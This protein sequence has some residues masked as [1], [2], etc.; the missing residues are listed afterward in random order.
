MK[1]IEIYNDADF[2]YHTVTFGAGCTFSDL[3]PVLEENDM[4]IENMPS[5]PHL[6]VVGAVM[7]GT[8]GSGIIYNAFST[9]INAI[10]V[11]K[12]DGS[13]QSLQRENDKDFEKYLHSFGAIGIITEMTMD[14]EE[15]YGVL[16]CIYQDVPWDPIFEDTRDFF[17]DFDYLSL[18]T[19]FY[20]RKFTSVWTGARVEFTD[21]NDKKKYQRMQ[22]S[23]WNKFCHDNLY[24]G[25]LVEN[26]HPVE[27]QDKSSCVTSGPGLWSQ[28]IFHFKPHKAPSS[29]GNEIQSEYFVKVDDMPEALELLYQNRDRFAHLLQISELRGVHLDNIPLSPA[30]NEE[31]VGIHF[32]WKHKFNEVYE[33]LPFIQDLLDRFDYRVHWGKLFIPRPNFGDFAMFG[34]DLKNLQEAIST[35]GPKFDARARDEDLAQMFIV[36]NPFVNCFTERLIFGKTYNRCQ[37][38][39]HYDA[40]IR[41]TKDTPKQTTEEL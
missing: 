20:D 21:R 23:E 3:I 31:V 40:Q 9:L 6:N 24:G 38:S 14:L 41:N 34:D 26:I 8:H 5:L 29:N 18:F 4:A 2:G 1:N 13:I 10:K 22:E 39:S 25:P 36:T 28:K 19:D 32:T 12:P 35:S 15:T 17:T 11:V 30:K 27:G 37:F 33:V 7:T 16:K